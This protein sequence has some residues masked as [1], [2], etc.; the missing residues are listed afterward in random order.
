MTR[1]VVFTPQEPGAGIQELGGAAA[2][3]YV[4]LG[5]IILSPIF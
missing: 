1:S 2:S 4:T 3:D 5:E